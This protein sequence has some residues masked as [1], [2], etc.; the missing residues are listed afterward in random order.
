MTKI[1]NKFLMNSVISSDIPHLK[2][3]VRNDTYKKAHFNWV[4]YLAF[5]AGLL[6]T[7]ANPILVI[8]G[9]R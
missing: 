9:E 2:L 5:N 1:S 8:M 4:H 6:L 3:L 7:F